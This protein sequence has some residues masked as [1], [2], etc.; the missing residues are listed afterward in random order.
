MAIGPGCWLG[1]VISTSGTTNEPHALTNAKI[2]PAPIP[3]SASG[4]TIRVRICQVLA[5]SIRAASSRSYG[6]ASMKFLIR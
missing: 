5:R 1:S 4:P 2:A 6:M 3:G